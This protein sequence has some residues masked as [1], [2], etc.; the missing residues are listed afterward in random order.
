MRSKLKSHFLKMRTISLMILLL[1]FVCSSRYGDSSSSQ[2]RK[3]NQIWNFTCWGR[4]SQ[5]LEGEP[6]CEGGGAHEQIAQPVP[7]QTY[8]LRVSGKIYKCFQHIYISRNLSMLT[9]FGDRWH[10]SA[11]DNQALW[12]SPISLTIGSHPWVLTSDM[13]CAEI[14]DHLG[15][16]ILF[17]T[18]VESWS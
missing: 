8:D 17:I 1:I 2:T 11:Y 12:F 9:G 18:W 7:H 14:F 16:K 10:R 13:L 15:Y 5:T 6:G 4:T 3:S